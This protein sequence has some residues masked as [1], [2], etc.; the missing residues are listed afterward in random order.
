MSELTDKI[1]QL[2]EIFED[3]SSDLRQNHPFLYERWKAGG[4]LVSTDVVSMY[5]N[6]EEIGEML[7]EDEED[8]DDINKDE[9]ESADDEDDDRSL[10]GWGKI[11][12]GQ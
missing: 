12:L 2:C 3:V 5:P 7:M 4:S 9:I 10:E 6:I 1:G 11:I 8:E